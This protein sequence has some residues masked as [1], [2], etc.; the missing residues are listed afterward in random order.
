METLILAV[1]LSV[2]V[3][4]TSSLGRWLRDAQAC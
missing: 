3:V 2:T 1:V 4:R